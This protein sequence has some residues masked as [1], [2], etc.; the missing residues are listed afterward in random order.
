MLHAWG[1]RW[2]GYRSTGVRALLWWQG[3]L[4][5]GDGGRGDL[6]AVGVPMR[7]LETPPALA[8]GNGLLDSPDL[9]Q[10]CVEAD[11]DL[12][13]R[14]R[15]NLEYMNRKTA[16][17]G[18]LEAGGAIQIDQQSDFLFVAPGL[19]LDK[20][21]FNQFVQV[22][23]RFR[24]SCGQRARSGRGRALPDGS[25]WRCG[26]ARGCDIRRPAA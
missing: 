22:F 3:L 1:R 26:T 6:Q 8:H 23:C 5:I 4:S 12:L 2:P 14:F 10:R 7:V 18:A 24:N 16:V 20:E 11:I 17:I 13:D 15:R 19:A 25:R 9:F 21:E